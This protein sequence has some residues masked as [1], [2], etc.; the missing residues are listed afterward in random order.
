MQPSVKLFLMGAALFLAA[1]PVAA[2]QESFIEH[3]MTIQ[4]NVRVPMRDGVTLSVDIYRPKDDARHP[5]I[6][7]LTPYNNIAPN[8]MEQAWHWVQRG[9]AFATADVRGRND[10]DGSF[11]PYRTDGRD[12][13][14]IMDWIAKQS[15]SNEKIATVGESYL[16]KNQWEMAQQSNPHHVAMAPYVAPADDFN[17][18]ARYNG[19]PKLDLM[20]TWLM[21]MDGRTDQPAN[22][23]KWGQVMRQLPLV[24]LD[25]LAG[26]NMKFW[27]DMMDHDVL[28]E[29]W[30]PIQMRGNYEKFKIP[31][32]NG[33]REYAIAAWNCSI[34]DTSH[35]TQL[36]KLPVP[37]I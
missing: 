21:G 16:G 35:W 24:N 20:Y 29:F 31:S 1:A 8:S 18:L 33:R 17:D 12:G 6:F 23:W 9:Y 5:T 34:G 22:G 36:I 32:F 3:P 2:Q 37:I 4:Y 27:Q 19:V 14:D 25:R 15:W 26:R 28:D 10:S 13:S 7:E 11:L 30:L